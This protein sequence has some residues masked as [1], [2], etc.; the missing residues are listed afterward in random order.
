MLILSPLSRYI[1][2]IF[3]KMLFL[4][5]LLSFIYLYIFILNYLLFTCIFSYFVPPSYPPPTLPSSIPLTA[6]LSLHSTPCPCSGLHSDYTKLPHSTPHFI[7]SHYTSS[8]YIILHLTQ[9]TIRE[10]G[11]LLS[12]YDLSGDKVFLDK[13]RE[14]GDLLMPAFDTPT[15]IA[16]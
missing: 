7:T 4:E 9:T 5:I 13:A 1:I 15:G 8:Y 10:L 3:Y 14:L 12:A 16:R 11:G 2:I 6:T